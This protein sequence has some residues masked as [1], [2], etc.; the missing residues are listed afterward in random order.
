MRTF[1]SGATRNDDNGKYDIEGFTCP[2]CLDMFYAYMHHH[3]H[4]EDGTL[5]DGDNWQN[6]F[7]NREI[8]KSELRHVHDW[9]M[10]ERGF[11][12]REGLEHALHGVIFNAFARLHNLHKDGN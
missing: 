4:L 6:G 11:K 1:R 9:R 5:R 10:E 3:R 12:S 8:L 2:K 7:D